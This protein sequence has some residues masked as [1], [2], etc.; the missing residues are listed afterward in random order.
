MTD[1]AAGTVQSF[2]VAAFVCHCLHKWKHTQE[3]DLD[4]YP[5]QVVQCGNP[6]YC[7]VCNRENLI[8]GDTQTLGR[9]VFSSYSLITSLIGLV[10]VCQ[11]RASHS[12][13]ISGACIGK[14]TMD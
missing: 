13:D 5:R 12:S 4:L 7:T 10:T 3:I 11:A 1:S 6:T 14:S 8:K 2:D 9:Q